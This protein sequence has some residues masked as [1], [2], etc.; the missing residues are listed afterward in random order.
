MSAD[1]HQPGE[2]RDAEPVRLD[3]LLSYFHMGAKPRSAWR[4]GAE[5]EKFAVE[6]GTG[7]HLTYGEPGGIRSILEALVE[8][9]GWEPHFEGEHLTTLSRVGAMISLE[10]GGQVEFSTPP[11]E[12]LAELAAAVE[13]HKSE[14]LA[15]T[16]PDE[17]AWIASGVSPFQSAEDIQLGVR[18]RHRLMA[19]YLPERC[20]MALAMMKATASTQVAFDYADEVDAMRKFRVA[21]T[22]SPIINAIW[23]NSP[24][25]AGRPTGFASYRSQIWLGMDPDRSGLLPEFLN[26]G[27]SFDRWVDYLLHVPM[28]FVCH[29]GQYSPAGGMTFAEFLRR[30]HNGRKPTMADWE[31]HLTTVFPEVRLKH[32]L[33][34]RGADANPPALALA[35]PALWMGLLY[36]EESLGLAESLCGT[37]EP[38]ELPGL[39]AESSRTGL[40][41]PFAGTTLLTLATRAVV[42]ARNGLERL[43]EPDATRFLTPANEVLRSGQSPGSAFLDL[44]RVPTH[45]QL[46]C[47]SEY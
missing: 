40:A 26:R 37:I 36:D 11:L 2:K 30:G 28:L 42:I 29:G 17:V 16:N 10:P 15:V 19:E 41:T 5:F 34:I 25:Y 7:R 21:L 38:Q 4:V 27:P 6:R 9:F 23:A 1:I 46:I 13:N 32:F 14:L 3:D 47:T 39:F 31:I 20:P 24:Y 45:E 43:G 18:A 35:V 22:L 33:E 44:K 12:T 8:R